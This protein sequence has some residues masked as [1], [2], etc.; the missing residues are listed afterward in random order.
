MLNEISGPLSQNK[1]FQDRTIKALKK[2]QGLSRHVACVTEAGPVPVSSTWEPTLLI[3]WYFI[4][5]LLWNIKFPCIFNSIFRDFPF[6]YVSF[7]CSLTLYMLPVFG[8][9]HSSNLICFLSYLPH[10]SPWIS[11][12][13]FQITKY[14][15]PL[16]HLWQQFKKINVSLLLYFT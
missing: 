2:A 3:D 14:L 15:K 9:A 7:W 4:D 8:S 6:T 5:T 11:P 12:T 16:P 13:F 10:E 1:D